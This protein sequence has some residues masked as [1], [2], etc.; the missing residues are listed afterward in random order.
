MFRY[1]FVL[2][3]KVPLAMEEVGGLVHHRAV[4]LFS[5]LA[6]HFDRVVIEDFPGAVHPTA[7]AERDLICFVP[8]DPW[9]SI[10]LHLV[11]G[12]VAACLHHLAPDTRLS[13]P[14]GEL[15]V[16]A[17]DRS[18][19]TQPGQLL[20]LIRADAPQ[21]EW[22]RGTS[23]RR[24]QSQLRAVWLLNAEEAVYSGPTGKIR[25]DNVSA[26]SEEEWF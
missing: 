25:K 24:V 9:K 8:G 19:D 23:R 3:G 7:L 5:L 17:V 26:R 14:K 22:V 12:F 13:L 1:L 21:V 6:R 18:P 10:I 20:A 2:P 16:E 11:Q 15:R 4:Q